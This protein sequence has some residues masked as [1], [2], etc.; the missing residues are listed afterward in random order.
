MVKKIPYKFSFKS[1][2]IELFVAYSVTFSILYLIQLANFPY[3]EIILTIAFTISIDPWK[4]SNIILLL[5]IPI[6]IAN[7]FLNLSF[8]TYPAIVICYYSVMSFNEK[9]KSKQVFILVLV[10]TIIYGLIV[11]PA[12]YKSL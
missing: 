5:S 11:L 6:I 4:S 3:Y 8:F 9:H 2:F 12:I 1:Y 10:L 7:F